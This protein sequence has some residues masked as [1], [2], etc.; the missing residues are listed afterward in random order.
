MQRAYNRFELIDFV[1][2]WRTHER[3]MNAE[4]DIDQGEPPLFPIT[5]PRPIR[6]PES[7]LTE[8]F[9]QIVRHGFQLP[10]VCQGMQKN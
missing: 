4:Q 6:E 5:T 7:R 8:T 2:T 10:S 9:Y 1:L 3:R